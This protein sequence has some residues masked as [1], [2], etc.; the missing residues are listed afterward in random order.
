[1]DFAFFE[2][3]SEEG[4]RAFLENY[5]KVGAKHLPD[6][7]QLVARHGAA[8]DFSVDSIRAAFEVVARQVDTVP[9]A[10]DESLPAWMKNSES[11]RAGLYEFSDDSRLLVLR[12]S[13]Y[14][15]ETLIRAS[16]EALRWGV[17]GPD[18]A[19][20]HQPVVE[21]FRGVVQMSP[22]L[23]TENLLRRLIEEPD[24]RTADDVDRAVATW[25]GL[26]NG[27]D[28]PP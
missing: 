9:T 3:L 23:V 26:V 4:A 25:Q 17:G 7:E 10:L 27:A 15:A 13:Y 6:L 16:G 20:Q 12:L 1:M 14:L 19:V 24:P 2:K 11:F 8:L 5:R 28:S 22:L 18:T 21:G